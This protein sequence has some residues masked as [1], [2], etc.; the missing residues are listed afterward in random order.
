MNHVITQYKQMFKPFIY[1]LY[2]SQDDSLLYLNSIVNPIKLSAKTSVISL[3][4]VD[5][6]FC[7]D[8]F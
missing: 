5:S 6:K 2:M 8:L 7:D 3:T 1:G 4:D